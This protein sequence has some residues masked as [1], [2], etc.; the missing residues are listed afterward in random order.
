MLGGTPSRKPEFVPLLA[1]GR[2]QMSLAELKRLCVDNF[3]LSTTRPKIMEGIEKLIK[4]LRMNSIEGEVW[5]DG[6]FVTEKM[7]PEDVDLVLRLP[8]QFYENATERQRK[9][10]DWLAANLKNTH[11]CDSYLCMEWPEDHPNYWIGQYAYSYWMRQFGFS[12]GNEMKG[13]AVV[14]L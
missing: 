1:I 4:E 8:A 13:I 9:A 10:V 5:I 2:H 14:T 7:D 3:P 6:S 12:R 11:S